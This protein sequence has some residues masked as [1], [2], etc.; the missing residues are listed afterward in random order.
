MLHGIVAGN[1]GKDAELKI[2]QGG[3]PVASFSVAVN[4]RVKGEDV[5]QWVRCAIWGKRGE[6]LAKHL[7]TGSRVS[8]TGPLTLRTYEKDGDTRTALELRVDQITLLGGGKRDE[9]ASSN[10]SQQRRD[11]PQG[12]Q[13]SRPQ[14]RRSEVRRDGDGVVD[15]DAGS[16][17]DDIP[18]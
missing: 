5:T 9:G 4:T 6:A 15:D 8:V 2:T 13:Q 7:T 14:S 16:Y 1:L 12:R 11:P 10:G 3:D 18:F 17:E